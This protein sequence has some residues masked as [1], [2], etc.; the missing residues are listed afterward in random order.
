MWDETPRSWLGLPIATAKPDRL[1]STQW[2]EP[3]HCNLVPDLSA[4]TATFVVSSGRSISRFRRATSANVA[5]AGAINPRTGRCNRLRTN[6]CDGSTP[7]PFSATSSPAFG[8]S[9][10]RRA[11]QP[12]SSRSGATHCAVR[13]RGG[14]SLPSKRPRRRGAESR[15]FLRRARAQPGRGRSARAG[16]R[17]R[18][19][20]LLPGG[21][22][23]VW[24]WG[25]ESPSQRRFP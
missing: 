18:R 7:L 24:R 8:Q 23:P 22:S 13:P 15:D 9:L 5:S 1:A 4:S 19:H 12:S 21:W 20:P 2:G 11:R 25:L 17:F 10:A 14:R 16:R 3:R 6:C